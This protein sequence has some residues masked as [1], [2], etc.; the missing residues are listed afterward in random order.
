MPH[1]G[2][3]VRVVVEQII[4]TPTSSPDPRESFREEAIVHRNEV[5][6]VASV[7]F[8]RLLAADNLLADAARE[9][10]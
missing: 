4:S 10:T 2:F 3:R 1:K 6:E 5:Y 9:L 7:T 8:G